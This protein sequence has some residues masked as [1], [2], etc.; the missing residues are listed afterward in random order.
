M[1][2]TFLRLFLRTVSLLPFCVLY[3]ISDVLALLVYYII[4]YRR[5]I[6]RRNLTES[7]PDK[8][9]REIIKIEK[10]FYRFFTDNI[11]ESCKLA[12][13][14][15]EEMKRRMKFVNAD[16]INALIG[17]R[18]SV[19]LFLGHYANWE[20]ISSMPLY[21]NLENENAVGAQIYHKLRNKT[22]D[23]IML[24]LRQRMGSRCVD[25][26]QTARFVNRQISEGNTCVIGFIA[27]QSPRWK[28]LNHYLWFL[29]HDIPVLTGTE[30][31]VK[32]YDFEARFVK[33]TKVRRG[34]YEAEFVKMC[35]QP[36]ELPD[37]ELTAIY[38]RMLEEMIRN[39]PE[40]YLWTHNRF[41]YARKADQ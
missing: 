36:K 24:D 1:S 40:L 13:I 22:M 23:R 16:E 30:K 14:S 17:Q 4:R 9:R 11:V 3:A 37:F 10:E 20:W 5:G 7:F 38:Y 32:H 19:G 27:D 33:V 6:V 35:D 39:R 34:Y 12:Y 21:L 31:I 18:R 25:M 41:K 28:E 8:T 2:Y 15:R 29:N 26:H